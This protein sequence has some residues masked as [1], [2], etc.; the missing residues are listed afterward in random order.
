VLLPQISF[1]NEPNLIK[2]TRQQKRQPFPNSFSLSFEAF[3]R[4]F[5][6]DL[7]LVQGLT[8]G[9]QVIV[10][11]ENDQILEEY[12][13]PNTGYYGKTEDGFI[14][15]N[16]HEDG[17]FHAYIVEGEEAFTIDPLY[18]HDNQLD[19]KSKRALESQSNMVMYKDDDLPTKDWKCG[20]IHTTE[21]RSLFDI[22]DEPLNVTFTSQQQVGRNLLTVQK[23]KGCFPNGDTTPQ[24]LLVGFAV[25]VGYYNI[26]KTTDATRQS[27]LDILTNSNIIYYTQVNVFLGLG[28]LEIRTATGGPAYNQI[29]PCSQDIYQTLDTFTAWRSTQTDKNNG[30]YHLLTN[31]FPPAGVVGLAWIGVLCDKSYGTGVSSYHTGNWKTVAHEIG[32]NFGAQHTFQNGIGTTGGI[33]DYGDGTLNGE[34]QFYTQYSKNEICTQITQSMNNKGSNMVENCWTSY[35]PKCGNGIVEENEDCDDTSAC[36]VNCKFKAGGVCSGGSCCTSTCQFT[37]STTNCGLDGYCANGV[38]TSSTC[39]IYSN[40]NFC[41]NPSNNPCQQTCTINGGTA[42]NL[43]NRYGLDGRVKDGTVC[44]TS[45]Y[46]TCSNGVCV[47]ST[48]P[49][50]PPTQAPTTKP[51]NAPTN[52]P[53][54]PPT[55]APT[56]KPTTQPT[57]QPTTKPTTQ[58]TNPP[59]QAPTTK[60]TT[61]PTNP[62]TQAPTTK[63]TNPPT[64]AP[65][66]KPTTQPTTQPTATPTSFSWVLGTWSACSKS[67]GS[68]TRTRQVT[69]MDSNGVLVSYENCP[70]PAPV[71]SQSCNT[72]A[73]A[74]QHFWV[75]VHGLCNAECG[76]TGTRAVDIYCASE[77]DFS[78]P[79]DRKICQGSHPPTRVTCNGPPCDSMTEGWIIGSWSSCSKSCGIIGEQIRS[80]SCS[81]GD[82]SLCESFGEKPITT[83]PCQ[84]P[85]CEISWKI[86]QNSWTQCSEDCGLGVQSRLLQ[87]SNGIEIVD[88]SLCEHLTPPIVQTRTC[89]EKDCPGSIGSGWMITEEWSECDGP[90][91]EPGTQTRIWICGDEKG[92]Q[93]EDSICGDEMPKNVVRP[94]FV[95]C[96][97]IPSVK[98]ELKQDSST[99]QSNV[100][101]NSKIEFSSQELIIGITI[102][103]VSLLILGSVIGIVI[104]SKTKKEDVSS[105]S[106][107]ES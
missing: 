18:Y 70:C 55:Q 102:G 92:A 1:Q 16:L 80:V 13:A 11:G 24:K 37:P 36:C 47:A 39:S 81:F 32:H 104:K 5:S 48:A 46:S 43:L 50:N 88:D 86:T 9:S 61:A 85:P 63:P 98:M 6:F 84:D 103:M 38:C 53:T 87:C 100:Q 60:P 96:S 12:E 91:N 77:N 95:P 76:Q 89:F 73:C 106:S 59:T 83:K 62:P 72:Q 69:C 94:C 105:V 35:A 3:G 99:S 8:D 56:T 22:E 79:V 49:T 30:I 52:P 25:D 45:P 7:E 17:L 58:P 4:E 42:C 57:T 71:T 54:N 64:Q 2:E 15:I 19:S 90:C 26:W 21:K 65:T 44:S 34:Y 101:S 20:A 27:V 28:T 74:A 67:C 41:N 82:D 78:T 10:Y 51:T 29:P 33:M 23:W 97:D 40:L 31:C 14:S 107:N 68:G 75:S 66:T 93:I